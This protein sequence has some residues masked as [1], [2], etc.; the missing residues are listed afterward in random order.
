MGSCCSIS[1][2]ALMG[3]CLPISSAPPTREE[4][5]A[6]AVSKGDYAQAERI[7]RELVLEKNRAYS[8]DDLPDLMKMLADVIERQGRSQEAAEIRDALRDLFLQQYRR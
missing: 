8:S 5:A 6:N 2:R 3:P 1:F 4:T 7:Y